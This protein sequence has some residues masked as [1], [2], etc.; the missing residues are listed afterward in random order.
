MKDS[1]PIRVLFVCLG[2]I[3][4]SPT[5]EGVFLDILRKRN[6]SDEF[7]VD[8]AGTGHWHIGEA[9]DRRSIAYAKTRGVDLS[10]LVARQFDEEDFEKFDY[11][12]CMDESNVQNVMLR[13]FDPSHKQKVFRLLEFVKGNPNKDVPD[14]Y[15]GGLEGFQKV[16]DLIEEGCLEFLKV[17][18]SK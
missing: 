3:C 8:S 13:S 7:E 10:S 12:L 6:L 11:I 9:P 17:I 2:N 14:P 15:M 18:Q 16:Y 1:K 4:R 5:A